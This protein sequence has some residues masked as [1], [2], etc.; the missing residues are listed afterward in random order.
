MA[1]TASPGDAREHSDLVHQIV[2]TLTEN[3]IVGLPTEAGYVTVA[4]A[5][6]ADAVSR[7]PQ[8]P[9]DHASLLVRSIDEAND[10]LPQLDTTGR[11]LLRRCWP[12][13]VF[14][15]FPAETTAGGLFDSL[16]DTVRGHLVDETV[17]C[18]FPSESLFHDV[19]RLMSAPLV[20]SI[21][22]EP[23][24]EVSAD[25]EPD[26]IDLFINTGEVQF[27]DGP[28]VVRLTESAPYVT[29]EGVVHAASIQRMT[30]QVILFVCTGNTCRS[31]MAEGMFRHL[32]CERLK[33]GPEQLDDHGLIV[34][35]AGIA[36]SY[37]MP[38]SPES[39][40]LMADMGIDI[41]VHESQPLTARLLNHADFVYTMTRGHRN[42][43]L[44]QRPDLAD[45]VHVLAPDGSD[46]PDPI[47][48]GMDEYRRCQH[49]IESHLQQIISRL[50][51]P[52]E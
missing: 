7:L 37:G 13:P 27:P 1:E 40:E 28:T 34:A 4:S 23:L 45:C 26:N 32:L 39:T 42:A 18:G 41:R 19:A 47:G 11:R 36:A 51:L 24:T 14:L 49:A 9:T 25:Q 29:R 44:A 17:T 8:R 6:S 43:I 12:G 22:I 50:S 48:G 35:S 38:A 3:G 31:P 15:E 2:Q 20:A 5:L 33:C 46:V 16:S 10:F 30:A 21:P 52:S